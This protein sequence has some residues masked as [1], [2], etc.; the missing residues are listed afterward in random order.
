[1]LTTTGLVFAAICAT[2]TLIASIAELLHAPRTTMVVWLFASVAGDGVVAWA[3][4]RRHR[5]TR[6]AGARAF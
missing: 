4:L 5:R 6:A 3:F 1:M 2:M